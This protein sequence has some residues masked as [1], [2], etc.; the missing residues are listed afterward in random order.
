MEEPFRDFVMYA[1]IFG[2]FGFCWFGWAQENPPKSWRLWLG[3]LSG[4]SLL[5]AIV[6]GILAFSNW[7][8]GSNLTGSDD[9]KLFGAVIFAEILLIALGAVALN[10]KKRADLIAGWT[11]FVVGS[12]FIPL[13]VLFA[14]NWLN[15]LAAIL[16]FIP[17]LAWSIAQKTTYKVNTLA[18]IL[19]GATIFTF[20][21]RGLILFL[22]NS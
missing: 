8:S 9:F 20:G 6:G 18:C 16:I 22:I 12:H 5:I 1:A 21:V 14:D 10:W 13:A 11:V 19:A 15:L 2:F 4:L 7:N 17:I 3:I